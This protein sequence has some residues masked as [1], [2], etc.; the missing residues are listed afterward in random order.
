MSKFYSIQVKD[1]KGDVLSLEQYKGN[2]V[3]VVNV[4]SKCGFTPQYK[5]LQELYD[6]YKEQGLVILG[7]PC[8]QFKEQEPGSAEE[9]Q[10]FCS[11]TYGVDFPVLDKVDVNGENEAP[12]YTFLKEEQKGLLGSSIKWNFTK[13]LN[14]KEGNVVKRYAPNVNP[15]KMKKDIEKYLA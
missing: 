13:F 12:L 9:I 2:V 15:L 4:A 11:L 3:V 1:A 6:T 14:D 5:D 8:N 10:S 7:F